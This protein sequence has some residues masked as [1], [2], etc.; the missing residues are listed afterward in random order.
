MEAAVCWGCLGRRQWGRGRWTAV[1]WAGWGEL[2]VMGATVAGFRGTG[3]I[4]R[5]VS[6]SRGHPE[7]SGGCQSSRED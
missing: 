3:S 6:G 1:W 7:G 4:V 5:W 2:R